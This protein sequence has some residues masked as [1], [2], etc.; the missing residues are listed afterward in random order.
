MAI[1]D[2]TTM[3]ATWELLAQQLPNNTTAIQ[4]EDPDKLGDRDLD[5]A[6]NWS[7]HVG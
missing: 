7:P 6:Y 2:I 5:R 4:L 3:D 1:D